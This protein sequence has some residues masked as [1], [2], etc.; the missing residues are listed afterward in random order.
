MGFGPF[1]MGSAQNFAAWNTGIGRE[2]L[3]SLTGGSANTAVGYRSLRQVG[4]G[5]DLTAVGF[6]ALDNFSSDSVYHTAIGSRALSSYIDSASNGGAGN[7]AV[8]G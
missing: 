2:S 7:T 8:G 6:Q 5:G 4:F 3:S 1:A